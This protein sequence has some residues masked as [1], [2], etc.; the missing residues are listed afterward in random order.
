MGGTH[1]ARHL[2]APREVC[3]GGKHFGHAIGFGF[4]DKTIRAIWG[5]F[6]GWRHVENGKDWMVEEMERDEIHFRIITQFFMFF[7]IYQKSWRHIKIPS[8]NVI[9]N[10][11]L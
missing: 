10:R 9:S 6:A 1:V 11:T 5:F 2:A 3:P 8:L 7:D 4:P